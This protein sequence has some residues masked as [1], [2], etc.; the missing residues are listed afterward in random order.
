MPE[1]EQDGCE[2]KTNSPANYGKLLDARVE[3]DDLF[4]TLDRNPLH[5]QA[6]EQPPII[7]FYFHACH[8]V[9]EGIKLFSSLI[10]NNVC[11]SCEAHDGSTKVFVENDVD[12]VWELQCN[13]VEQHASGYTPEQ[14]WTKH[15]MLNF[16]FWE[17]SNSLHAAQR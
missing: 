11:V 7:N 5:G 3:A 13:S 16:R 9:D 6:L 4:I 10:G 17:V 15:E 12:D 8:N 2:V 1:N 14:L